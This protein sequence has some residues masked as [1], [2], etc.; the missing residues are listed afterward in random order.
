MTNTGKIIEPTNEEHRLTTEQSMKTTQ[1]INQ[2][3][4]CLLLL[5]WV[6]VKVVVLVVAVV[7]AVAVALVNLAA[8]VTDVDAV[9]GSGSC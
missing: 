1:P 3:L 8:I 4:L 6:I 5:L 9:G 2:L 7:L